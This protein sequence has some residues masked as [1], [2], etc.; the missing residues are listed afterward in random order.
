VTVGCIPLTD[1][2]IEEVYLLATLAKSQGQDY[3][4]VHIFPIR[5]NV[6]RSVAYLNNLSKD[7]ASLRRFAE[8]L[9]G[10]FD[11]FEKFRQLP[12]IMVNEKGDYVV[13]GAGAGTFRLEEEKIAVKREL[14]KRSERKITSL[15]DAVH[16]WP[17]FPGGAEAYARYLEDLGRE[18]VNYLPKGL[19]KAY[20]QVEF[21]VDKDGTPVNFRVLR[22]ATDVGFI[23]EL[24]D[25]MEK[26]P[27]WKPALLNDKP[28][29]KKMVQTISIE[30]PEAI[31]SN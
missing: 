17:K 25:R 15:A 9:E 8:R 26:M 3:I 28:V 7:D 18:M 2:K 16:E 30:V 23:D 6:P 1:E 27:G 11:F 29:A 13:N 24:L 20:V 12:V 22:G 4:P 5:Y 21:I 14:K 31:A 19:R 10:A